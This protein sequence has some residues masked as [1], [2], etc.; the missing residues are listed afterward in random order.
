MALKEGDK[1]NF[2]T[3]LRAAR[4]NHLAV[5]ETTRKADGSYVAL[6]CAVV[7]N[8]TDYEITPFAEMLPGDPFEI[9]TDP[10]DAIA[11]GNVMGVGG[12]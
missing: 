7:W 4:G 10:S 8:G 11:A 3:L 6:L 1:A 9:Y 5:L 12:K 2:R